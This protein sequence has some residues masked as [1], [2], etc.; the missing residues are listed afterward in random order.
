MSFRSHDP[1]PPVG[2]L[3][4]ML[5]I[6]QMID[7][8]VCP[9][10][11]FSTAQLTF[12][13][14]RAETITWEIFRGRLVPP[15]QT[16][17]AKTF[18]AWNVFGPD[19]TEPILSVKFDLHDRTIHV[20]R[21]L[22]TYAWTAI[23]NADVI[24]S[25]ETIAWSRELVGSIALADVIDISELRDEIACL[26][27][28]AFVGTSRL[29]LTS[30]EA[31]L[32][33]YVLG[34]SHFVA[35][36]VGEAIEHAIADWHILL[37]NAT[38]Q[39]LAWIE[40]VKLIEFLLRQLP[41]DDLPALCAA[42]PADWPI[43]RLMRSL[44]NHVSLSPY[45]Q[46][47]DNALAWLDLLR[48]RGTISPMEQV[49]FHGWLL[50]QLCR[51]LTAYDLIT[52]HH[53]GANYPDAL[54]LDAILRAYLKAAE[55]NTSL[56]LPDSDAS[57]FRR[58]AVR[59]AC[60][61]RQHYQGY[62][63]PDLPTSPGENT[64]VMPAAFPRLPEEQLLQS[65][66]RRKQLYADAPLGDIL[67]PTGRQI[68]SASLE[69]LSHPDERIE[70]GIG[71]FIDR[72]LGY[73][74][75]LAEPDLTPLLA[76]ECFSA[77]LVRR[78]G[79]E[80][81]DLAE[82]LRLSVSSAALKA[83]LENEATPGGLPHAELADCPRPTVALTDVRKVADDFLIAR[84]LPFGLRQ[85]LALA[86]VSAMPRLAVNTRDGM[87]QPVLT[88]FDEN[89]QPTLRL[90]FDLASGYRTRAGIEWPR[91]G[92]VQQTVTNP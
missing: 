1:Y 37:E 25:A 43:A 92:V 24:E 69:D 5:A 51:H 62:L 27:W 80:L 10:S 41:A 85:L 87:N 42:V 57:R 40:R 73:A 54:A 56:F 32:P 26:V 39:P 4:D 59:Q 83:V 44:F 89:L 6:G 63:V 33:A 15:T 2:S 12:S 72:P 64:R 53:R 82:V 81:V 8:V 16:R 22:L 17:Q 18:L 35:S 84:T 34:Q 50:R 90:T 14:A 70:Q 23:D 86:G 79:K 19:A 49:D 60:M 7:A 58:R 47:V 36:N 67:T 66:R 74:K 65:N 77:S 55:S 9:G 78:R 68:L 30:V 11:F 91:S 46:L 20:V 31:P 76:H 21:S 88:L 75:A 29:P 48:E 52:F 28:Q 38:K 13:A 71:L 45:T 61:L 3:N